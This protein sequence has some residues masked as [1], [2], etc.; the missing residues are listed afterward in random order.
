[1]AGGIVAFVVTP[2]HHRQKRRVVALSRVAGRLGKGGDERADLVCL[3]NKVLPVRRAH[4]VVEDRARDDAEA[5]R[6]EGGA[7]AVGVERHVAVGAELQSAEACRCGFI[8]NALPWRQVRV[9]HVVH[10]PAAGRAGDGD[11]VA[12]LR[13]RH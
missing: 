6:V 13:P 10:A 11:R 1:M 7:D 2:V 8:E 3:P 12:H 4:Q 5:A 9:L